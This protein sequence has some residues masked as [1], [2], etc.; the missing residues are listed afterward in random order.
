MIMGQCMQQRLDK[1]KQDKSWTTVSTSY[2][3]LALLDLIEKT[4]MSQYQDTYSCSTVYQAQLSIMGYHH[5]T[6]SNDVY[7]DRL[8]TKCDVADAIGLNLGDHSI[9]H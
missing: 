7:Y 9:L 4:V 2:D 8:N 5:N 3:T 6:H 1:M